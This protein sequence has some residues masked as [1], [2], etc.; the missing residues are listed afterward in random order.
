MVK[1]HIYS[2]CGQSKRPIIL[3]FRYVILYIYMKILVL[4]YTRVDVAVLVGYVEKI[5]IIYMD[6]LSASNCFPPS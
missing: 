5:N 4:E 2:Y 6:V 3:I 1:G